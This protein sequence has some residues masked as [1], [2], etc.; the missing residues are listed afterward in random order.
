[1]RAEGL[2]LLLSCSTATGLNPLQA[3]ARKLFESLTQNL[4]PPAPTSVA[5]V[6]H[7]DPHEIQR[8]IDAFG[9]TLRE[10]VPVLLA[11]SCP[12]EE[13][14]L[15]FERKL[16]EL[17]LEHYASLLVNDL[18]YDTM[19][20]MEG[21]SAEQ[22][23][24]IAYEMGMKP[25]HKRRFVEAFAQADEGVA[26]AT[27][28]AA[29]AAAVKRKLREL[30]L[31]QY[32]PA[33]VNE[34][35]YDTIESMEGLSAEVVKAI[36]D[37]IHVKPGHMQRFVGAFSEDAYTRIV[38]LARGPHHPK[39]PIAAPP[40]DQVTNPLG[41]ITSASGAAAER[42]ATAREYSQRH[43]EAARKYMWMHAEI[44]W[45][46]EQGEPRA[47]E[48]LQMRQHEHH[49]RCFDLKEEI[50]TWAGEKEALFRLKD[51]RA[52]LPLGTSAALERS[53]QRD[54]GSTPA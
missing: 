3:S 47:A 37:C 49:E 12:P 38:M 23:G 52:D 39:L 43:R 40:L 42:D 41:L 15:F 6:D 31:E 20:S 25:G 2:L 50:L 33:L 8:R 19:E 11:T 51:E 30:H 35:G 7:G 32:A 27:T 22:V 26:A 1:M 48:L 4:A 46:R 44:R 21:L 13:S 53:W 28:A 14:P 54:H 5:N 16:R 45:L 34:L 10:K 9:T 36:A 29:A 17:N 18:G 24:A